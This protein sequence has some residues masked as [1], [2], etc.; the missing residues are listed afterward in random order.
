MRQFIFLMALMCAAPCCFSQ[1]TQK[2]Q[3]LKVDTAKAV[4]AQDSTLSLPD[5]IHLDLTRD[6]FNILTGIITDDPTVSYLR[7]KEFLREYN[8]KVQKQLI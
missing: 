7:V 5:N 4:A 3:A 1:G 2:R 8:A 6:Q